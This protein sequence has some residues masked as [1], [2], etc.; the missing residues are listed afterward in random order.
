M[1]S[2]IVNLI[3]DRLRDLLFS[4]A[5]LCLGFLVVLLTCFIVCLPFQ[6]DMVQNRP[7]SCEVPGIQ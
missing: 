7:R 3:L 4:V 2:E 5:V 1:R 6:D